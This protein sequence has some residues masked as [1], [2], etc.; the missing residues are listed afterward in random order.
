MTIREFLKQYKRN[1]GLSADFCED[2]YLISQITDCTGLYLFEDTEHENYNIT[3]RVY[4]ED[5][6]DAIYVNLHEFE[7]NLSI[8]DMGLIINNHIY[9]DEL[10][11]MCKE[12]FTLPYQYL[13]QF[14][15]D[16][17]FKVWYLGHENLNGWVE[18]EDYACH[19]N[20]REDALTALENHVPTEFKSRIVEVKA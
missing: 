19:F 16:D 7:S 2:A 1:I 5:L 6:S 11:F 20:S 10:S 14:I 3:L 9:D 8:N 15:E 12:F 17:A 13:V 4:S 18:T